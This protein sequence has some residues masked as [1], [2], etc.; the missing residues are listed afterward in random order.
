MQ[1]WRGQVLGASA[2]TF[3]GL[4]DPATLE[5]H[6]CNEA[7]ALAQDLHIS[8]LTIASDCLEVITNINS[9][10]ASSCPT[11][12]REINHRR[13]AF[14]SASFCHEHREANFEAHS[15]AKASSSLDIGRHLWLG[16]PPVIACIPMTS[17][18][19]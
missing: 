6:A 8:K 1:G 19:E 11:I 9:G 13:L 7:L 4:S 16:N 3:D 17:N 10:A 18:F 15:L 2:T 12:L 5:A 14:E